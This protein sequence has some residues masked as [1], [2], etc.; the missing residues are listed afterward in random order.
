[1]FSLYSPTDRI[2]LALAIAILV[3]AL[4]WKRWLQEPLARFAAETGWC[5][6]TLA[7]LPVA[8]RLLLL[9]YY[10][11]PTPNVADDFSYVLL[12]DTLRHLRFANPS[13]ALPQFF[14]T[15]F[16]IQQ[17]SYSSMFP[18]GQG[19]V[20]AL[21]WILFGNPWAGVALSVGALCALT[22]WMLRAWITPSW[23]LVGGVLAAIEFGPLNQ[24]MNSFWG[25]AVS[26]CAGCLVFGSLPRL[27]TQKTRYAI[28]LGIGLSM[29]LLT[30]PFEFVLLAISVAAY[31]VLYRMPLRNT[32]IVALSLLPAMALMLFQNKAVTGSWTTLPYILNQ[33]DYGVPSTFTFQPN[34]VP[35]RALTPQQQLA[36]QVQCSIHDDHTSYIGRLASRIR[37]YRF[38]FLPPL[39]LA[40]PA[41]LFRLGERRIAWA[42]ATVLLFSFGTN[43]YPYFFTHYI[44]AITCLLV[45]MS[46][47]GLEIVSRR[48]PAIAQIILFLCAAHFLFWYSLHLFAGQQWAR[49]TM[50]YETWDAINYGDP[51]GRIKVDNDL[52]QRP[53]K[54][55]VFVRY[56]TRKGF[57]AWVYNGANIDAGRIVWAWDLGD[58]QNEKLQQYYSDRTAWLFQPD[59]RPPRLTPL[60]AKN[61]KGAAIGF[62]K[63]AP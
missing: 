40:L 2:E 30:R 29:Q 55:L 39:Y 38:F 43:F 18:L 19:M 26:A 16:V 56:S 63:A 25:G 20:L 50:E 3:F 6:I 49:T 51:L 31:F 27:S 59:Y 54:H 12:A 62:P 7:I 52:L 34:P 57:D 24:W 37:F 1:M 8:L 14:E 36:Y 46:V 21:G 32:G 13:H 22:Y 61:A 23:A 17:P 41:L 5:M 53:G 47:A 42:L 11:I 45:L 10:P 35:H 33:Y 15:L 44:A 4:T 58:S 9:P 28:L 60:D 48:F